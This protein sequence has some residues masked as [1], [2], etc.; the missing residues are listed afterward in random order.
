MGRLPLNRKI[1]FVKRPTIAESTACRCGH[2]APFLPKAGP[3]STACL[4]AVLLAQTLVRAGAADSVAAPLF[5]YAIFYNGVLEFSSCSSM[6]INGPVPAALL[7][8]DLC[9]LTQHGL[10][11]LRSLKRKG[12]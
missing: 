2:G 8:G 4:A 6:T 10:R 11:S 5:Q 12:E 1:A 3:V 7:P 9:A